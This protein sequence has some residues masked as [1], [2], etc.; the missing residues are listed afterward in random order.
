LAPESM[1]EEIKQACRDTG[2]EVPETTG[3]LMRCVY[4]SLTACYAEA[5]AELSKLTG[6][7]YTSIN[8]VGGGCQDAYLND[9]TARACGLPVYAGPIE[10]TSLGNLIVQMIQGGEFSDLQAARAAIRK[11]FDVTTH[12]PN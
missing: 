10:G 7:T 11:S 5:I 1:I 8:V 2:Q 3:A 9:Q 6:K 12:L 4:E